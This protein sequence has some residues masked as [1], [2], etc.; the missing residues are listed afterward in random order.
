MRQ[1]KSTANRFISTPPLA[2]L[3][4]FRVRSTSPEA[5]PRFS[6][7]KT[8]RFA[9]Q[10]TRKL[11]MIGETGRRRDGDGDGVER[12]RTAG[13]GR[14][15]GDRELRAGDG[16][17]PGTGDGGTRRRRTEE[18]GMRVGDGG[19][20]RRR[21]ARRRRDGDGGRRD[22]DGGRGPPQADKNPFSFSFSFSPYFCPLSSP[23][24]RRRAPGLADYTPRQ[25]ELRKSWPD[26]E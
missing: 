18:R 26:F 24:S 12:R 5:L 23:T 9:R 19:R 6:Y 20:R 11:A 17:E 22:G 4:V 2:S 14:R 15:D 3:R 13:R 16:N 7:R 8:D 1:T 21:A 10:A 25:A